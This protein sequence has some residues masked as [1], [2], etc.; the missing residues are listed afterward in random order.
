MGYIRAIAEGNHRRRLA[1]LEQEMLTA[2]LA[3]LPAP[4]PPEPMDSEIAYL[5]LEQKIERVIVRH[6]IA[7]GN[8]FAS[9]ELTPEPQ[10][11]KEVV[12]FLRSK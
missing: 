7:V 2:E 10:P 11:E 3:K 4:A 1:Q 9:A 12:S 5:P 8:Y 6:A